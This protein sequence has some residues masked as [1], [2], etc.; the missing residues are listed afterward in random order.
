MKKKQ[1]AIAGLLFASPW[2]I[3]LLVFVAYPVVVSLW[4]SVCDYSVL[5]PPVY[6]GLRNYHKIFQDPDFWVSLKNTA[7][8]SCVAIPLGTLIN[9][10]VA[11][12]LNAKVKGQSVYRTLFFIPS[13]V[14]AVPLAIMG[15]SLFNSD[16][17]VVNFLLGLVGIKGP[18]WLSDPHFALSVLVFLAIWT[19][20][21]AVVIYLAGLQEVPKP[22]YEAAE[23]DGASPWQKT[24]NVTIPLMSPVILFNVLM[25]II[26]SLQ[27]FTGAYVMFGGDGG[28]ARSTFFYAMNIFQNAM[29]FQKMGYASALGWILFIIVLILTLT[30]FKFGEKRVHYEGG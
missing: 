9:F 20:G 29:V 13:L 16:N 17:G 22:L 30:A 23:L 21:N 18:N 19:G 24:R 3:G 7:I 10:S 15:L 12:L 27:Y 8:F 11:L 25:A 26:G 6:L 5:K 2:L 1:E 14:P 4:Y 28:P